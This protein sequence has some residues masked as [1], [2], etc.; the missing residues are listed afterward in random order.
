MEIKIIGKDSSNRMKLIKNV[1]RALGISPDE[2]NNITKDVDTSR[3]NEKYN[4]LFDIVDKMGD[5]IESASC[6][7]CGKT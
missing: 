7:P 1:G 2:A 4:Q 3:K 5:V 6:N